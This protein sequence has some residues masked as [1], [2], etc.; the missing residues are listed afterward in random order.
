MAKD[1]ESRLV[2]VKGRPTEFAGAIIIGGATTPEGRTAAM[3]TY[4]F[5]DVLS[6][7]E[8]LRDLRDWDD[9]AWRSRVAVFRGW[10]DGMFDGLT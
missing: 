8:M 5:A 9:A 1:P 6:L 10:A 3:K 4:G 7:E 2:K